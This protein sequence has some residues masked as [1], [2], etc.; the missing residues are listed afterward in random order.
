MPTLRERLEDDEAEEVIDIE[1]LAITIDGLTP[2][3]IGKLKAFYQMTTHDMDLERL[4]FYAKN[5]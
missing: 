2:K 1:A 3:Q 5:L 4:D